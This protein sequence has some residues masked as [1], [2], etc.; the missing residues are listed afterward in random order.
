MGMFIEPDADLAALDDPNEKLKIRIHSGY[1]AMNHAASLV[2][3]N[4]FFDEIYRRSRELQIPYEDQ[5]SDQYY[6]DLVQ[7]LRDF[8][9]EYTRVVEVGVY[10]GGAS[11]VLAGCAERFA[12]DIDL[13][14]INKSF[15]LFAYERLRRLYPEVAKRVRLFH[16]DLPDYVATVLR[17]DEEHRHIIHH[18]GAHAF[19]EVVRD[20]A[21]LSFVAD[22]LHS[23]IAQDT[24]LRGR[25]EEMNFVDMALYAV[26]GIDMNYAPIGAIYQDWD[27]ARTTPNQYQGNYFMAD[28][29]EGF[30]VPMA[31]NQF[32]YPHPSM[33]LESLLRKAA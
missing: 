14:D 25:I 6:Y 8:A 21:S 2:G 33:A 24:H 11:T 28:A 27:A 4:R 17:Q 12:F 10:M 1:K 9:G 5:C 3:S 20:L 32:K 19:N 23:I 15:L 26:F 29:S 31:M 13:V 22:K 18:D 7:T 16:G 30:V